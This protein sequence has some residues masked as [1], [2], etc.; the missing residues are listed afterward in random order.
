M[1]LATSIIGACGEH[2]IAAYLSGYSLIVAMPRGG[3]PG[4]DLFVSKEKGG[5]TIRVQVKTARTEAMKNDRDV[6]RIYLWR[7]GATAA[8]ERNDQNL[9]Y[10]YV[11]LNGWP[12]GET[13][14]ETFFV[15]SKVVVKCMKG[16]LADKDTWE[17]FWMRV[18]E[19]QKY[20]G[21]SGLKSLLDALG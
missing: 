13:F 3:I 5:N 8:I 21:L 19:A 12:T 20:K 10:A 2:Y 15:P 9:W 6:G 1:K 11:W 7:T 4:S 16:V 17:Y 18:R 14:P